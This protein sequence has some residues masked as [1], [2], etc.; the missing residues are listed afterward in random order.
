MAV[1]Y[2]PEQV[3]Q[4]FAR[5]KG[6]IRATA[7][8]LNIARG[9]VKTRLDVAKKELG[10]DYTKPISG[11]KL[12]GRVTLKRSLPLEGKVARYILTSIQN[13]TDAHIPFFENL[14]TYAEH[15]GAEILVAPYTYNKASYGRKSVRPGAEPTAADKAD[16]FYD[17]I[18]DQ[19]I[20]EDRIELAPMLIFDGTMDILP[21]ARRPLSQLSTH[22]GRASGIF[23]HATMAME[24]VPGTHDDG[25]K[26]N[27]TTGTATL[28]NYIQKRAGLQA[29]HHH[30]Y[31]ALL[32]EVD[33]EG[34]WFVRQ[35]NADNEGTFYDLTTKVER[36]EIVEGVNVEAINWGDVHAEV[37]DAEAAQLAWGAD[38]VLD[39]LRPSYQFL[40]D[41]VDFRAR[42]HHEIKNHHQAFKRAQTATNNVR[43]EFKRTADLIM[44][45]I[46]RPWCTAVVVDSN[47]DNALERWLREADYK[48]DPTN[49]VFFLECEL[50]KLSNIMD[51]NF[52]SVREALRAEGVSRDVLFLGP[53]DSFVLCDDGSGGIEYGM[54]GHLGPNGSKGTPLGLSRMGRK[55]N[56]GHTHSAA[57]VDGMYVAGTMTRLRLDYNAG[58]S[59]WSHSL[60]VTYENGKR[61]IITFYNGK[62]RA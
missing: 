2:T 30:T 20:C 14:L 13:N 21:T 8:D 58:P 38:G 48:L 45:R 37:V 25:A 29:E 7:R 60:I 57:I 17:A 31:G 1:E 50:R 40:H 27:Y 51:E 62:W 9:T 41:V 18:F 16:I 15:V 19:F 23:P 12:H 54:H 39:Q 59:S 35:L 22:L 44:G 36:C 10:L 46:M 43:D 33:H 49:A 47:H 55:A 24:S 61:A 34:T 32:V 26:F 4:A 56:T 5:N 42:N 28:R 53:D 6:S 11:G 52:H 3:Y